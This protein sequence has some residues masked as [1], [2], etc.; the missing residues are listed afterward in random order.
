MASGDI[1]LPLLRLVHLGQALGLSFTVACNPP[2]RSRPGNIMA[3]NPSVRMHTPS[4]VDW[5]EDDANRNRKK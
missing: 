3:F 5:S 1:Y 4:C 2:N